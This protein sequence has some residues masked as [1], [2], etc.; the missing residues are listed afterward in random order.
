MALSEPPFTIGIEEEYMIVDART[1][2][3]VEDPPPGLMA[4][5]KAK[6]G[7]QVSTEFMRSQIEVGTR[8]RADI[9]EARDE[10]RRLRG[11]I[12]EITAAHGLAPIAVS[13]HPFADYGAQQHTDE[14]RY[15]ILARDL[16]EVAGAC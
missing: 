14:E 7:D 10:L 8:V 4:E 6:L 11:C 16:P 15:A 13:T 3:L 12:A 5:C 1:G 9:G 2:A